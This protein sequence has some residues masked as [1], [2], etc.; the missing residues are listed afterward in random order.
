LRD[1]PA[2]SLTHDIVREPSVVVNETIFT[3]SFDA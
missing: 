3:D 1:Q 2:G